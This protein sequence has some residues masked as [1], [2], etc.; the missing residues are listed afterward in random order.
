MDRLAGTMRNAQ[1]NSRF[2]SR[3][4]VVPPIPQRPP[5]GR[6]VAA[7]PLRESAG[8]NSGLVP[9]DIADPPL[10]TLFVNM[11]DIHLL[12][13]MTNDP[14]RLLPLTDLSYQVLLALSSEPLH[15]YAIL[16]A[17]SARTEGRLEPVSG[18][19][20][21]AIRRLGREGLIRPTGGSVDARRGKSYQLTP[22]G[23]D[24][25][26]EESRRLAALVEEAR[27]RDV[28]APGGGA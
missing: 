14:W 26:R 16:K 20:Y 11:Y 27:R 13:H 2:V 12:S 4:R 1:V 19:L 22:L 9:L 10:Y 28:L 25:L 15:G 5:Q 17:I 8:A 7:V 18:T 24:V 6:E 21:T 3:K 23:R